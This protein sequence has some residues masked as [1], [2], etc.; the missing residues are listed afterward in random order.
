MTNLSSSRV[1]WL[2]AA[3]NETTQQNEPVWLTGW[4]AGDVVVLP[5]GPAIPV[6]RQDDATIILLRLDVVRSDAAVVLLP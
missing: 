1:K 2:S 6:V 3:F 5:D 4:I